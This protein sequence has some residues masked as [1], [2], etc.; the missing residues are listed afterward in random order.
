V[1]TLEQN[2]PRYREPTLGTLVG[3]RFFYV[4]NSQW[5]SFDENGV[6]APLDRLQAPVILDVRL[7]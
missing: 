5:G 2:H 4:A 6:L 1:E 3:A 7:E